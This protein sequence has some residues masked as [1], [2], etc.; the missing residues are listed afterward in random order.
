MKRDWVRSCRLRRLHSISCASNT[1]SNVSV[2]TRKNGVWAELRGALLSAHEDDSLQSNDDTR[3]F[4]DNN[5]RLGLE[6]SSGSARLKGVHDQSARQSARLTS[7]TEELKTQGAKR[8][9]LE[10]KTQ[11]QHDKMQ[12]QHDKLQRQHAKGQRQNARVQLLTTQLQSLSESKA[13]LERRLR[14]IEASRSWRLAQAGARI[15]GRLR[16]AS[17]FKTKLPEQLDTEL[18]EQPNTEPQ[19]QPNTE[20]REQPDTELCEQPNTKPD[21]LLA[22]ASLPESVLTG[23]LAERTRPSV[24]GRKLQEMVGTK[25]PARFGELLTSSEADLER[26]VASIVQRSDLPLVSI[27]MPTLNRAEIIGDSIRSVIEQA[28][29]NWELF[30]CDDASTDNTESVVAD[31]KDSRIRYRKLEKGGAAAARNAGLKEAR[32]AFIAYLDSDNYWHP[33]YLA[34]MVCALL[35]NSGRSA[36]F[37]NYVDFRVNAAGSKSI[38]AFERPPFNQEKLIEKN[39]IDLNTFV[40]R[41]EL[42]DVFGGFNEALTRRQDYDLIIKYTWLRDPLQVNSLLTLYQRNESLAQITTTFRNDD[43]CVALINESIKQYLRS[44]LP[45]APQRPV[46]RVTILSWDLCRNHFSKPFALAEALSQEYEVQLVAFRFFEEPIFPPLEGVKPSFQTHYFDGADFPNFFATMKAALDAIQ[47]D[48]VY[49]VKPRLPSLGLALLANAQ[50]GIPILLEMNDLET[51]V[52]SPR[53]EDRHTQLAFDQVD[54]ADPKLMSPYSDM[55]SRI[56][57]P[58]AQEL[59]VLLTHNKNIDAHFGHRCLYMRNLKDENTYDVTSY[60][61]QA[62]RASLGFAPDDRVILFGGMLRKHKGIYELVELMERLN[63]PRYKLLFVGSRST[64]D[65]RKLVERYGDK[66]LVLPPQN[67]EAMARINYAADMVILWLDPDVPAS[68]YQMPYK[69]TDAFAMGPTI[70]AND[71]SDLGELASQGYLHVVPYGDWDAMIRAVRSVFENADK[72]AAMREASRRLFMRQFSYAAARSNFEL[73]AR[74]AL[75]E[76]AQPLAAARVFADR[77]NEFYRQ[78]TG[79]DGDLVPVL[80]TRSSA[81][82]QTLSNDRPTDD[83]GQITLVNPTDLPT[84]D[85]DDPT[86]VAVVMFSRDSQ[87]AFQAA[88]I[89]IRRAGMRARIFIIQESLSDGFVRVLNGAAE[90]V[91]T[92]YIVFL[93]EDVFPGANWLRTAYEA[94]ENSGKSLFAF[95]CGRWMGKVAEFGMVRV[96]WARNLYGGPVLYPNYESQ[97]AVRELTLIARATDEFIYDADAVVASIDFEEPFVCTR[98]SKRFHDLNRFRERAL[99]GFDGRFTPQQLVAYADEV[100]NGASQG[101]DAHQHDDDIRLIDIKNVDTLSCHD[102]NGIAVIMPCIDTK[103]GLSTARLLARRAGMEARFLVVEDTLRQGFIKTLNQTASRLDVKYVVYLAEDAVPGIDWLRSAYE[104]LE[105]SGKGLLAFNCGKW[106]GRIAAFGM[107]RK[108]WAQTLYAGDILHSAYRSHRADNEVTAIARATNQFVY[109]PQALLVENDSKKVFRQ[110]EAGAANF[111]PHDKR[112]FIER[113]NRCFDGLAKSEALETIRD[114]YL[115][116]RKLSA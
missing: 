108:T 114:E 75:S 90:R 115:N 19:E 23:I 79:S 92:R 1:R 8:K 53:A 78:S 87:K 29:K 3:R 15:M 97:E 16:F 77:F 94:L 104:S 49:V 28:Y 113:F 81:T 65:Q 63:D 20:R 109:C 100:L 73:A 27:I 37:G 13:E 74:R 80:K 36:V 88:R 24:F 6:L 26:A 91:R 85:F 103:R 116:Q 31:F 101:T 64:P 52:A 89:L 98:G 86:G 106:R 34:K 82:I 5:A 4:T 7:I 45:R 38:K 41:C 51:V 66:V 47:G 17:S 105:L 93:Q 99:R 46:K 107:V 42:Y 39:F 68:H 102:P 55:W 58:F 25:L 2:L 48:I 57:E 21:A 50:R 110:S 59:P 14:D 60:D 62:T 70:I 95:N 35:D 30:V 44:G 61:R 67:R 96:D 33:A 84:L 56:M 11:C 32:G 72:T 69:A 83:D 111:T 76:G 18:P 9:A 71:I 40:H 12:R 112:L 22:E 43:S 54:L 10:I